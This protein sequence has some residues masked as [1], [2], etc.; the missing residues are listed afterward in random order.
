[1]LYARGDNLHNVIKTSCRCNQIAIN[2]CEES[3]HVSSHFINTKGKM[4]N[5]Q[6]L[7]C[8]NNSET[9]ITKKSLKLCM[10][11]MS[12][13]KFRKHAKLLCNLISYV[14]FSLLLKFSLGKIKELY[15][16]KIVRKII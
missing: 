16:V 12:S 5:L 10:Q 2:N 14:I 1:M 4:C 15:G 9:N 8:L 11:L 13:W 6:K 3:L 7:N